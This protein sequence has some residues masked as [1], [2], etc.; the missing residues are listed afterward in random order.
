MYDL[1]QEKPVPLVP[2]QHRREI[3]A[4][5]TY[6]GET[7]TAVDADEVRAIGRILAERGIGS[8]PS[9]CSMPTRIPSTSRRSNGSCRAPPE[10]TISL[11][12]DVS[13]MWREF[14]R[15]STTVSNAATKPIVTRYL[16]ELE[17]ELGATRSTARC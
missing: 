12:S 8:S 3:G 16:G 7:V 15:T 1:Q 4:R 11:S 6:T 2:R 13:R 9:A 17:R 10:A 14:E 5:M